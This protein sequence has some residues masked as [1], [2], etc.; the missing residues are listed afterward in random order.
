MQ[1]NIGALF[2]F[3]LLFS[4]CDLFFNN[5]VDNKADEFVDE[6]DEP[7][8]TA[9]IAWISDTDIGR[10]PQIEIDEDAIYAFEDVGDDFSAPF[11]LVKL[12]AK[13]GVVVWRSE[14]LSGIVNCKPTIAGE[15]VYIFVPA[16][17]IYSFNKQSGVLSAIVQTDLEQKGALLESYIIAYNEYLYF[18]SAGN[19]RYFARLDVNS[20]DRNADPHI[21][22]E[23]AQ[24]VIWRPKTGYRVNAVPVIHNNVI[25]THTFAGF[26]SLITEIAGFSVLTNERC[27]YKKIDYDRGVVSNS[28]IVHNDILYTLFGRSISAYDLR[29]GEQ[30]YLKL[31]TEGVTPPEESYA[32]TDHTKALT[33]YNGKI[34]FT[35]GGYHS[36]PEDRWHNINCVDAKTGSLV[37]NAV[38]PFSESLGTNP[39]IAHGKMYVPHGYGL[40][41]YNPENGKLIGVD[42]SYC[43]YGYGRNI[44]YGDYLITV[45]DNRDTGIGKVV[46]ID[47]SK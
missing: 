10:C 7:A 4:S 42:T 47:V 40:R 21:P 31:F 2:F 15:Y 32:P 11:R 23:L 37:W 14:P 20:I 8:Y 1:K 36:S 46:A 43:G 5:K 45:M 6:S 39:I 9:K 13:T 41:V 28:L 30:L 38:P 44:L 18:G 35:D 19:N 33:W 12:E 17:Y 3:L 25:Y 27:F 16:S 24:E 29:T 26:D 34:Y 22:Q